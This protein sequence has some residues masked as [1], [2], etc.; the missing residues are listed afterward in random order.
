MFAD[1]DLNEHQRRA[2]AR[3]YRPIEKFVEDYVRLRRCGWTHREIAQEL[4]YASKY[5]VERLV[6]RARRIGLLPRPRREAT[7]A[8]R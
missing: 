2:I 3:G 6:T 1:L 8:Q 7:H 4:G 5:S